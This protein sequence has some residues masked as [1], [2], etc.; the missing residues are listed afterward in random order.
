MVASGGLDNLCTISQFKQRETSNKVVAEL[1]GH[2]G[3]L[4][5]TRFLNDEQILTASGDATCIL[6]DVQSAKPITTFSDHENDVM[7]VSLFTEKSIFASCSCDT[8]VKIWDYRTPRCVQ[9]F[10][11][12]EGDINSVQYICM[13]PE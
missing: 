2:S 5:C 1:S 12:H 3:Y 8:L 6:W 10:F 9:T 13:S 7:S 4:S 11:G